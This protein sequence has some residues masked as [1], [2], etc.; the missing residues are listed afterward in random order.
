MTNSDNFGMINI[1]LLHLKAPYLSLIMYLVK[2]ILHS[3]ANTMFKVW[4][5][6]C[7]FSIHINALAK[8]VAYNHQNFNL[9]ITFHY[10][11]FKNNGVWRLNFHEIKRASL[12]EYF[13]STTLNRNI[14][15]S[16]V[17]FFLFNIINLIFLRH[18]K[19]TFH[20]KLF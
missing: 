13:K 17:F 16:T 4:S 1:H 5:S 19:H 6:P 8:H 7:R 10:K 20:K 9:T 14:V 18:G 3:L 12:T 15:F 2:D 11:V